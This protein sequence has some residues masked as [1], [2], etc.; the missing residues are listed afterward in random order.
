MRLEVDAEPNVAG[1]SRVTTARAQ[2]RGAPGF[3]GIELD[4]ASTLDCRVR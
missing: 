2:D 1:D 3:L 4:L